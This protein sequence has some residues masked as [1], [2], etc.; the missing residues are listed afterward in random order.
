MN[1]NTR[2]VLSAVMLLGLFSTMGC[3]T[4]STDPIRVEQD[5]G[6]SVRHMIQAQTYNPE[7]AE[8][9][10]LEPPEGIDGPKGRRVLETYRTDVSKPKEV[11]RPIRLDIGR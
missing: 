10:P 8:N 3:T 5:Y 4:T 7:A 6:N 2:I 1:Y 9:P 11:E